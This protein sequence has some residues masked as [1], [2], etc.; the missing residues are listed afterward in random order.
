MVSAF[1][2]VPVVRVVVEISPVVSGKRV[3]VVV[4]V[5]G[6]VVIVDELGHGAVVGPGL[7]PTGPMYA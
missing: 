2:V 1:A 7:V 5:V 3:V 6:L 4:T